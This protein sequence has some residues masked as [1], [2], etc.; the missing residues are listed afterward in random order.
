MHKLLNFMLLVTLIVTSCFITGCGDTA[1]DWKNPVSNEPVLT[2]TLGIKNET[3]ASSRAAILMPETIT[4]S[5]VTFKKSSVANFITYYTGNLTKS[6]LEGIY[7]IGYALMNFNN[8]EHT[9]AS[10][11]F[12]EAYQGAQPTALLVLATDFSTVITAQ[13]NGNDV[14]KPIVKPFDNPSDDTKVKVEL[15][16]NQEIVTVTVP[17]SVGV[18]SEFTAWTIVFYDNT[19][20]K[21]I[22]FTRGEYDKYYD[23]V[24]GNGNILRLI[25]TSAGKELMTKGHKYTGVLTNLKVKLTDGTYK[26][27]DVSQCA[28]D[29]VIWNQ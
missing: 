1:D 24:P 13:A 8:S 28:I 6:N 16:S 9:I 19:V 12:R 14:A 7:R 18:V 26:D 17:A 25:I 23:E 4:I 21:N 20:S 29:N 15:S 10:S 22:T 3:V 27:L 2:F 5:G 11:F